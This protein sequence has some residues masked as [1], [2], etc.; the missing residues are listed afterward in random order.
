MADE[1]LT[2]VSVDTHIGPRLEDLRPYCGASLLQDFDSFAVEYRAWEAG[3]MRARTELLTAGPSGGDIAQRDAR[4]F[5]ETFERNRRTAGHYDMHARLRDMDA[6]GVAAEVIFHASLN[7]EPIPFLMDGGGKGFAPIER[8]DPRVAA[9]LHIYN[10]WLADVCSIEAGRHMGLA[11]LPLWDVVAS[12]AELEWAREAGLRGVNFPAPR[13]GAVEYDD[14]AWE[15]FWSACEALDAPLHTHSGG[16]TAGEPSGPHGACLAELELGGWPSR[17]GIGR[18]LFGGVFERHPGLKVVLTE[19]NGYWW[20]AAMREYDSSYK[21][22]WWQ[23][24]DRL[25]KPPSEYCREQVFIGASFLAP[26]EA[27]AA[28]EEGY[29]ANVMW[30]S[31]YPHPEGTYQCLPEGDD[32]MT[33][34]SLRHAFSEIA[35]DHV[36]AMIG[37]NA[38]RTLG[39]DDGELRSVARRISAPTLDELGQRLEEMPRTGGFLAFRT[40]GPWG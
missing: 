10:R 1:P 4:Q 20:T 38:V 31:D 21:T 2:I 24:S 18:M 40:I 8:G 27:R 39:F 25:R 26:F 6:D 3:M 34:L 37:A 17:R 32:N 29:V 28:I 15:P 33:R 5:A 12:V 14:R 9:G 11:H 30:G 19:Q 16:R 23:L 35:P 13:P 36:V 7:R 22:H